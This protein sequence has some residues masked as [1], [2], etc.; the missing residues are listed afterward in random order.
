[1]EDTGHKTV[2]KRSN[3][4]YKCGEIIFRRPKVCSKAVMPEEEEEEEKKKKKKRE[5]RGRRMR[6]AV[7][8]M[9]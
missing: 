2:K 6:G 8:R 7:R 9:W 5:G 4:V 3:G 1:M